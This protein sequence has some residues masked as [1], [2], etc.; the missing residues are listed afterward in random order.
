LITLNMTVD[1]ALSFIV[2]PHSDP[3]QFFFLLQ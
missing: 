2:I 1:Q 3:H